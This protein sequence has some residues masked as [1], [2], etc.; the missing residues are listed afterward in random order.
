MLNVKRIKTEKLTV[1]SDL[2]E[3]PF[4]FRSEVPEKVLR[5]NFSWLTDICSGNF[6]KYRARWYHLSE[7]MHVESHTE[8]SKAGWQGYHGDSFFSGILLALSEDGETYVVGT[9]FS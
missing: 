4:R 5:E 1:V 2:K 6:F 9:Y 8:F 7:F 3:K